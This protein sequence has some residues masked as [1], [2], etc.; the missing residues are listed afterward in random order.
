MGFGRIG[1][2]IGG[3][4]GKR[5]S[6]APTVIIFE[7][8]HFAFVV[9]AGSI[10]LHAFEYSVAGKSYRAPLCFILQNCELRNGYLGLKLYL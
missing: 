7:Y 4:Y 2:K 1:W 10:M 5:K 9:Y 3:T 6:K 8:R